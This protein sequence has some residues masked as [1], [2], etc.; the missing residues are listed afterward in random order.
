MTAPLRWFAFSA[1]RVATD[2]LPARDAQWG[3]AMLAE[4]HAIADTRAMIRFAAGCIPACLALSA[5]SRSGFARILSLGITVALQ[6]LA[7]IAALLAARAFI[8]DNP[9]VTIFALLALVFGA[10][11]Y[12]FRK[13]GAKRLAWICAGL[14]SVYVVALLAMLSGGS[15]Q[16][17]RL[18]LA[19]AWEGAA[20]WSAL[21]LAA[22]Y[23]LRWKDRHA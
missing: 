5:S 20:I 4:A 1:L 6:L 18:Y 2:L 7:V 11:A 23:I 19:L 12:A 9:A 10:A 8:A 16:G 3:T 21:L 15:F 13:A 14:L 17:E 22:L